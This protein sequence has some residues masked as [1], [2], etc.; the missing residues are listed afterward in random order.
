MN[1][2]SILVYN[3]IFVGTESVGIEAIGGTA[4]HLSS[5]V[6]F[7]SEKNYKVFCAGYCVGFDGNTSIV[8]LMNKYCKRNIYYLIELLKNNYIKSLPEHTLIH[9]HR[10]DH[11]ALLKNK[12]KFKTILSLHGQARKTINGS[13]NILKII[14]FRFLENYG[15]KNADH[16]IVTDKYTQ[17]YYLNIFPFIKNKISIVPSSVDTD[18]FNI[19]DKSDCFDKLKL[20]P[21][22]KY[23][24]YVGRLD[25]PKKIKEIIDTFNIVLKNHP[26]FILLIIGKGKDKNKICEYIKT[27]GIEE[28]VLLCGYQTNNSLPYYYNISE[29]SIL[30]SENEG[31]P[32]SIKESLACGIPVIANNV[33]DINEVV[34]NN[35]NG[36][37]VE[38]INILEIAN[39][40]ETLLT[41][42]ISKL[43]CRNSI[44]GY[45]N[46]K[47]FE[48]ITNLYQLFNNE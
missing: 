3:N 48:K 31:S 24:L 47:V 45:S 18:K 5:F 46:L 43:S 35:I 13:K 22:K 42:N 17:T 40:I 2:Q 8:S 6:K 1:Y 15:I 14:I 41:M 36:F 30:L 11:I 21:E 16:I 20:N 19:I 23:I 10:S 38:K 39:R 27:I 29:F 7:L 4:I 44:M 26:E 32:I 9:V 33:G 25:Y 12:K 28:K 37:C 34:L